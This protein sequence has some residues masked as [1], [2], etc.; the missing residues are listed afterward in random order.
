MSIP[1]LSGQQIFK[2]IT[3]TCQRDDVESELLVVH[4]LDFCGR[5]ATYLIPKQKRP[6]TVGALRQSRSRTAGLSG[7]AYGKHIRPR[8]S[9]LKTRV[10]IWIST[11]L[12]DRYN[13]CHEHESVDLDLAVV[14]KYSAVVYGQKTLV[15]TWVKTD[16][17]IVPS[18]ATRDDW[19]LLNSTQLDRYLFFSKS[20]C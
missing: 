6:R 7:T 13:R 15:D 3:P 17:P 9:G 2:T 14:S 16:T 19:R 18:Q 4:R 10:D 1:I 11:H 12:F 5:W 20:P 8:L